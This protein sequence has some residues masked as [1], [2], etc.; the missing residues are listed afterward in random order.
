M[1]PNFDDVRNEFYEKHVKGKPISK[2]QPDIMIDEIALDK[3]G[4]LSV[5]HYTKNDEPY[6]RPLTEWAAEFGIHLDTDL[7]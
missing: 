5:I 2:L 3:E 1:L 4:I 7:E 6:V